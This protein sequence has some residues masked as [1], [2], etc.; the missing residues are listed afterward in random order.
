[1]KDSKSLDIK[2]S[3]DSYLLDFRKKKIRNQRYKATQKFVKF[4]FF[5][6]PFAFNVDD[7]FVG[8]SFLRL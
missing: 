8:L 3:I 1:M 4:L 6:C 7:P 2:P 5:A